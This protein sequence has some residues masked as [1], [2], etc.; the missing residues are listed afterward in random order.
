MMMNESTLWLVRSLR[1]AR[2]RAAVLSALLLVCAAC[3]GAAPTAAP[4]HTPEAT[5]TTSPPPTATPGADWEP[6]WADEFDAPDGTPPDPERWSFNTGGGGWGNAER[7]VYTDRLE[8]AA[9]EGGTLLICAREEAEDYS[10][11]RYTSAR[12]VTRNQGDWTYGR[13][14][15]RARLPQG[16][17]IWPAI[18]MLPSHMAYGGWPM[19]GEID[20]MEMLGQ[21][22]IRVYGTLHYGNPHT[23]TGHYYILRTGET[24]ADGYHDFAIEWEPGE[25]RW[26]VDGYHY[27]TQTEWFTSKRDAEYPAPFDRPFH[28]LL[29]VAVGGHWP[30]NP[31]ETTVFPQCMAV[32]YVRVY[33][34]AE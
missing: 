7:Q 15:V 22:P 6:V 28:L 10:G 26:Y 2:W 5:P 13:V 23:H 14:E 11:Y 4:T 16:Q 24:F 29:N 18:W 31:D 1:G 25:I 32:D 17:G 27:Q 8:N 34:S 12:L 21:D 3:A 20:I 30:G 19:G 33:Q 9:I